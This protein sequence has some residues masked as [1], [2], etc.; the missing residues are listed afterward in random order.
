M[1]GKIGVNSTEKLG[2]TFWIEL[3]FKLSSLKNR[4][5]NLVPRKNMSELLKGVRILVA[6]DNKVNQIITTKYLAKL[7]CIPDVVENGSEVLNSLKSDQYDLIIMDGQMPVLDGYEATRIIRSHVNETY[8]KIPII[9][10]T[11]N[12]LKGDK[13]ICLDAGM[14]DYLSKPVKFDEFTEKL[15]KWIPHQNLQ[16]II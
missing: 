9:A 5:D 14:N 8:S 13:D 16:K 11:A 4:S 12:A 15:S 1:N 2:S 10:M 3:P 6:E 7:G